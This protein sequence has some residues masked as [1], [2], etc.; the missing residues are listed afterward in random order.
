M[1]EMQVRDLARRLA[2]GDHLVFQF[3]SEDGKNHYR[4][5][6]RNRLERAE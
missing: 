2:E 3:L 6:A 4:I 5:M 1:D